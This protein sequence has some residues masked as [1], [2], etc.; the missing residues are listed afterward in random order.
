MK[1]KLKELTSRSNGWGNEYRAL[2]L[3]QFIRGW[4]N[5]FALADMK[6]L[7][8]STDEW[9]RVEYGLSIGNNGRKSKQDTE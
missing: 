5:Y 9:L 7:L 1:A 3:T 4:V 8:R 2:K 6:Q